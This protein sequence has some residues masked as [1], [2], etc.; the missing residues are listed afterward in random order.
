[1]HKWEMLKLDDVLFVMNHPDRSTF[2]PL[3]VYVVRAGQ[4][5]PG[6]LSIAD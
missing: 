6:W 1:M 4:V 5:V 2:S 3:R